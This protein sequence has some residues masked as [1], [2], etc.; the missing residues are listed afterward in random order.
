MKAKSRGGFTLIELLVVIAIIALLASLLIPAVARAK[1]AAYQARCIS[2]HRQIFVCW[3]LYQDDYDSK[4]VANNRDT[5]EPGEG[6]NWVESTIHGAT[7]GFIETNSLIRPDRAAFAHYQKNYQIY[8]CPAERT[9]Y[10]VGK[11]SYRKLRS[12]SMNDHLNGGKEQ[13]DTI[14]PLFFYKKS[15]Q[16]QKPAQIFL[17]VDCDPGT[18]CYAPFEISVRDTKIFFTAPGALHGNKA[19]VLSYVDGHAEGHRWKAPYLHVNDSDQ[20]SN[21]HAIVPSDRQDVAFIRTR[22]H[23]LAAP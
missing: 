22:A 5:R 7:P 9:Y 13:Y 21:P 16:I 18:I 3:Q 12:Y 10:R 14:P 2:N 4:L 1:I 20:N 6:L 8:A 11:I 15:S 23:H 19:A 17:L